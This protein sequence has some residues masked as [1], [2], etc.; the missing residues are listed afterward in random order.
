MLERRGW[1]AYGAVYRAVDARDA[2]G[3]VA[4]KL[5]LHPGDARFAR[6]AE[7]LSRLR[8]P[9]VPRL[10]DHGMLA[11]ARRARPTP[12]SP[13]SGWR[14]CPCMTGRGRSAPPRGRCSGVLAQLARALEATHAAGGVHRDVKGDNVLVRA[15]DGQA[16]LTDFGSGHYLGAATLTSPPFPPGT[17]PYRSPEAWRSVRSPSSASAVPYA[18]GPADDVFAL[19]V[20]AYRLVTGEY[21]PAPAPM[22][23][24][25]HVWRP[26]GPGPRASASAQRPL[27]RGAERPRVPDALRAPRGARQCARAGRGAGAGRAE[28]GAGGGCAALHRG[29]VSALRTWAD[30]LHLSCLEAPGLAGAHGSWQPAWEARSCL[31][32][33]GC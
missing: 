1:G 4:L 11:A 24:E 26:E 3:P 18:P 29:G 23:A 19:G 30:S 27:L 6:E 28:G 8:H 10:L 5:A 20:T 22:D 9:S 12:T 15:A 17:P 2:P 21:P 31:A 7:L 32:P 13:W 16:F 25:C 33:G 14:A